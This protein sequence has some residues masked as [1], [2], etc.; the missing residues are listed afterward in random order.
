MLTGG[1]RSLI[2]DL[3][4]RDG[5]RS[6]GYASWRACV[7]EEFEQGQRRLYQELQAGQIERELLQAETPDACCTFVQQL[8]AIPEGHLRPLTRLDT[9]EERVAA[10]HE[11]VET[12]PNGQVTGA[13]VATVVERRILHLAAGFHSFE[14]Y[15]RTRFDM[16]R[17]T[18]YDYLHGRTVLENVPSTVH[19]R[20][21]LTQAVELAVLEPEQQRNVCPGTQST[22][23]LSQ[24]RELYV[25]PPEQQREVAAHIDFSQATK[26]DVIDAVRE[27]R[28]GHAL[29]G[30]ERNAQLG[31]T[32]T[33]AGR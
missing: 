25:L 19:F 21:S 6:L 27:V 28:Q 15:A 18:A 31:V 7:T 3:Y 33:G 17:Q 4:E 14:D 2:L 12:A 9:A 29:D 1:A 23:S 11:A 30:A 32:P 16:A 10:W 20:P 22:P 13:H 24:A 26:Q 8:G 5:W